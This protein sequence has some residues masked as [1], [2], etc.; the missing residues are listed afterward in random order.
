MQRTFKAK[1]AGIVVALALAAGV[2]WGVALS[3]SRADTG[4]GG[5]IGAELFVP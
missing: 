3:G 1:V 4:F 5:G 2:I